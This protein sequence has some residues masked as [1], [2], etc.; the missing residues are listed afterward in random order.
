MSVTRLDYLE[1]LCGRISPHF[2]SCTAEFHLHRRAERQRKEQRD[3]FDAVC[4]RIPGAEDQVG[5][6][7]VRNIRVSCVC[8][9]ES[10]NCGIDVD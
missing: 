4:V 10:V 8:D 6:G 5:P 2:T 7:S 3:R 1:Y 9:N